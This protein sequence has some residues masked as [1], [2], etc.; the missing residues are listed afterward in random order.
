MATTSDLTR[1]TAIVLRY[2]RGPIL[3]LIVVYGLGITGMSLIK[4][5][6]GEPM[7]LFHAFYFFTYTATTTGFGELPLSF[8]DTQRLWAILCLY[9]GAI[10][11]LFAIGSIINLVQ[12]PHFSTAVAERRFARTVK[13]LKEPFIIICGFGD[14]GSL[15]ARGLSDNQI[16]AVVID[17]DSERIKALAMRDY[18]VNMP[19]LCGDAG[20][21]QH[22]VDAGVKHPMCRAVVS[23]I[24]DEELDLKIA[25]MT[26]FLN[27]DVRIICR[28]T[29][30]MQ[31]DHLRC[32]ESVSIIDPFELFGVQ[33]RTAV[34][35][36]KLHSLS[37]WLVGARAIDLQQRSNVPLGDWILCGYGRM[38]KR[39]YKHLNGDDISTVIIDPE[40]ED[41]DLSTLT[42]KGHADHQNL[43]QAGIKNA[44][45][46]VAGTDS[47]SRNLRIL[48]SARVLNPDIFMVVRQNH[49]ENEM[50]FNAANVSLSMQPSLLTA[51]TI[52]LLLISPLIHQFLEHLR[53]S[54]GELTDR[55]VAQL[56]HILGNRKPHLWTK[57]LCDVGAGA[58]QE[59]LDRGRVLRLEDLVRNPENLNDSLSCLPLVLQRGE[60]VMMLPDLKEHARPGDLIVFCGDTRSQQLLDANLN[61]VYTL[62]YLITGVEPPRGY[63]LHW[64]WKRWLAPEAQAAKAGV[65]K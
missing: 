36:P 10:A 38:G 54:D 3:L 47:D 26:R 59:Q 23:L 35:A 29:E 1:V 9:M 50:V 37:Q 30:T 56:S 4:G 8:T 49:H 34:T 27:P 31:Q 53:C 15:L 40:L 64:I 12:N 58:I 18:W 7:N 14:T 57:K 48:L 39:I 13:A 62:H 61:N 41:N 16:N 43:K 55:I 2:M 52:L 63:L 32:L 24:P 21:P 5:L 42:I 33:L 51:R 45:G 19:G 28:A 20:V 25:V 22:L 46:V 6:D 60:Q 11:W 65:G 44:V 17:S